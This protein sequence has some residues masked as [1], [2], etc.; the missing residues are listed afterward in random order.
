ME[1]AD[2]NKDEQLALT[3]LLEYVV[4]ASGHVTQDEQAEIDT[5]VDAIGEDNYR[6]A[7][8]EVDRRFPD[9]ATLKNFLTG[10]TRQEAREVIYGTLIEAAMADTVEGRE[11]DL[12]T[13]LAATWQVEVK[14]EQ[15]P[16]DEEKV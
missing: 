7:V 9:E 10:V 6:V 15:P 16:E 2:L 11:S 14:Y 1:L 13:W 8:E 4:L 3:G 12:L 5:I